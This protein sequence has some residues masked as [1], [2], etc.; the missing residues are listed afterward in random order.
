MSTIPP[1]SFVILKKCSN[2]EM[3]GISFVQNDRKKPR[4]SF[5]FVWYCAF[6][7]KFCCECV[8][9]SRK[10]ENSLIARN[11]LLRSQANMSDRRNKVF[12]LEVTS[13]GHILSNILSNIR[14]LTGSL[15]ARFVFNV[16]ISSSWCD[17]L[18]HY[19]LTCFTSYCTNISLSTLTFLWRK[20]LL[21]S[22]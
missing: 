15:W 1:E 12:S 17:I 7:I 16:N 11:N 19:S 18:C 5:I 3:W 8:L 14:V 9:L 20:D 21:V 10:T 2:I 6:H 13:P 22:S 4:F